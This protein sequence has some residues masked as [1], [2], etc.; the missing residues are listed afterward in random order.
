[1]QKK[2]YGGGC[3]DRAS[4]RPNSGK[5]AQIGVPQQAAESCGWRLTIGARLGRP[6]DG[7][8]RPLAVVPDGAEIK[9]FR[10]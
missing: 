9:E 8:I 6:P 10:T 3:A 2:S 4:T 5:F 1:V 7:R